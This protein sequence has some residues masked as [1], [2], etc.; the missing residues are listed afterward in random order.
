MNG[1]ISLGDLQFAN[2]KKISIKN[3]SF[4]TEELFLIPLYKKIDITGMSL[5]E[6]LPVETTKVE[7][8][9]NKCKTKRIF[10]FAV[11]GFD[12]YIKQG[13]PGALKSPPPDFKKFGGMFEENQYFYVVAKSD[14]GHNVIVLFEI[15]DENTIMKIGQSPSIYEMNKEINDKTF[16][17]ELEDEYSDYYRKACSLNSFDSNIGAMTYLRRIFEKLLLECFNE[18]IDNL[19]VDLKE[20]KKLRMDAKVDQLK[21]F[22]PELMFEAGYNAIYNKISDGI[23][24]LSE[25]ECQE[26]FVPLRMAIE[27]ILIEKIELKNKRKRQ[28]ELSKKLQKI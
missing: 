11:M 24:N 5:P 19:T 17:K 25:D 23:H 16:L 20:F 28:A 14:C 13:M 12:Y 7:L 6:L 26:M 2:N 22:L 27:E 4:L 21:N 10:K 8:Y 18:N 3:N 1:F 15:I 9:C